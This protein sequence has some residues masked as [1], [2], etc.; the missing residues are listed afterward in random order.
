[1]SMAGARCSTVFIRIPLYDGIGRE[2]A[3]IGDGKA[4][5]PGRVDPL[6]TALRKLIRDMQASN[7][8]WGAP[9]T[10]CPASMSLHKD[11]PETRPV[12]AS[13]LDNVVALPCVGGLHHRYARIA[14]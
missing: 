11:S 5:V 12:D 9:A 2:F 14:A 8:G 4:A 3:C 13:E 7:I 10:A 6:Y 1:M